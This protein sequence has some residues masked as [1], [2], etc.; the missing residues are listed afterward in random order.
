MCYK[1][2]CKTGTRNDSDKTRSAGKVLCTS[3]NRIHESR[4]SSGCVTS[5]N[6]PPVPQK[7]QSKARSGRRNCESRD[8]ARNARFQSRSQCYDCRISNAFATFE[9]ARPEQRPRRNA[10]Y[11]SRTNYDALSGSNGSLELFEC[12]IVGCRL[13]RGDLSYLKSA[14]TSLPIETRTTLPC[15]VLALESWCA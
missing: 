8:S 1:P 4:I 11:T 12:G 5:C 6:A 9:G 7:Y 14:S 13:C 15:W 2:C 10:C 3:G